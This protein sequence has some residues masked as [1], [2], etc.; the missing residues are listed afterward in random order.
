MLYSLLTEKILRYVSNYFTVKTLYYI[1]SY[2]EKHTAEV[3][4]TGTAE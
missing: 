4:E 1:P 2:K 3:A